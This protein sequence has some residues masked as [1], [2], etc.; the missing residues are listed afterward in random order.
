MP[1]RD[2]GGI[3]AP[4]CRRVTAGLVMTVTLIAFESLSV[5]TVLPVVSR[6][7]GDIRLYGWVFSA[8]FLSSLLG[9]VAGGSMAD[10]RGAR[11]PMTAGLAVFA[12]GLAVGGAAPDMPVLVAGRVVQGLGAGMVPAAAYVAIGIRYAP[13]LRPRMLA[14]M[15][16]AWVVPGLVGPA[17]AAQVANLAGWRW[18]FVGLLPLVAAAAIVAIP[19]MP[20]AAPPG[21]AADGGTTGEPRA[22][23]ARLVPAVAV[24]LG[25]GFVLAGLSAASPAITAPLVAVGAAILFPG[26]ARLTPE[27]T[28]R[29]RPGV[30]AAVLVRGLLTFA[31]FAGDAYVPL[32]L[33]SVRHTSTTF[34]G[35]VLTV[36]TVTWTAGAWVQARLASVRGARTLVSGGLVIVAVGILGMASLLSKSVPL[37]VAPVA[38]GVAGFG[39]GVAY[40]PTSL[41]V[42]G[43][44][45][46]SR[47]GE[48]SAGLQLSD[49]LG[50][51][52]GTGVSGAA[53]AIAHQH[54]AGN[55]AG[56]LWAFAAAAG[57]ASI[58]LASSRRLP[59]VATANA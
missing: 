31:Y 28:L 21:M 53:V 43:F 42:L 57:V 45:D 35:L 54:G 3:W 58:G 52:L 7:L 6:E 25:A 29:A 50:T 27:G 10:R 17:L 19:A 38:W 51:A 24:T 59:A 32:A 12:L 9:T 44:A 22:D 34:A 13:Q 8:F 33:T 47:V 36:A 41:I 15:S 18:V 48:A 37:W 56:L 30:P 39:I 14:V 55:R 46:P 23:R 49:L 2:A 5:A 40:S 26:L 16:T 4:G 11:Y 1:A 20:A